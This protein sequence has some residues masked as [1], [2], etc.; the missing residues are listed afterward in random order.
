[1]FMI[2]NN[3]PFMLWFGCGVLFLGTA[4][5]IWSSAVKFCFK[6]IVYEDFY[7][8]TFIKKDCT[9]YIKIC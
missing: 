3:F 5:N 4:L 7:F 8:S 6:S 2:C 1:M 9:Y